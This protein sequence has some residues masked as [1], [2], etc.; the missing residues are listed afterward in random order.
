MKTATIVLKAFHRLLVEGG[1]GSGFYNHAGRPGFVGGS[2]SRGGGGGKFSNL[3][4][5]K[6]SKT[7]IK[8][9][10]HSP[11]LPSGRRLVGSKWEASLDKGEKEVLSKWMGREW[12]KM[13]EAQIKN[14][15]YKDLEI[16]NSALDKD[17]SYSGQTYRGINSLSKKDA[18]SILHSKEITLN[19]HSSSTKLRSK[20]DAFAEGKS[21]THSVVFTI[22]GKSG[23][24][25]SSINSLEK[26][27]ILKKG[28]KYKVLKTAT[29]KV[30]DIHLHEVY[31][32]EK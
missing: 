32:K 18:L 4:K 30:G 6:T 9:P 27:V 11:D 26:E 23:V 24:D 28:T 8:N 3:Q 25:L 19:A 14:R 1:S 17:G 13:R 21:G 22:A 5:P 10:K 7:R 12:W 29:R 16:L 15:P 31:L 20:A 2:T